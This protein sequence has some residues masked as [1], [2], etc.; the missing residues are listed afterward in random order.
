MELDLQSLFGLRLPSTHW[1]RPRNP[2]PHLPDLGSHTRS[3]LVSQDRRHL[4]VT[5]W[6]N[7]IWESVKCRGLK[8]GLWIFFCMYPFLMN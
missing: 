3:L 8:D 4:F 7:L 1:L 2:L 6:S 5:P